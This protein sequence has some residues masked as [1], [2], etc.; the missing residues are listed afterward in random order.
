VI[1][2]GISLLVFQ[3]QFHGA[4]LEC[5]A[6]ALPK[7]EIRISP[8]T[9]KIDTRRA[10]SRCARPPKGP[11]LLRSLGRISAASQFG[12]QID[13]SVRNIGTGGFCATLK[14]A[15]LKLS[16]GRIIYIPREFT[17]DPCLRSLAR[18][19][20]AKHADADAKALNIARPAVELAVQDAL[21]HA[22]SD[23]NASRAEALATLTGEI[24][25]GV[26]RALDDVTTVRE[27]L[28]AEINSKA[29]IEHLRTS[30][31]ARA[32]EGRD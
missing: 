17:D 24:Q 29:E 1:L 22:T 32:V 12:I 19:H 20:E 26:N 21:R 9:D 4:N 8:P 14:Y 3:A 31:E 15:K 6:S 2:V 27:R 25:M 18:D 23:A 16:L 30:C 10:R 11:I 5:A 28:D 7:I 13:D